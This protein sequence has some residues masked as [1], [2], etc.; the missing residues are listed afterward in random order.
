MKRF[1]VEIN[2]GLAK[3]T[4]Q[5]ADIRCYVTYVQDLPNGTGEWIYFKVY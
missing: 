2:R 3:E 5:T 4:H 1:M